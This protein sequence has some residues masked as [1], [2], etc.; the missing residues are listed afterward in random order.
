MDLRI[1]LQP[2]SSK[3]KPH[4]DATEITYPMPTDELELE[5]L[6]GYLKDDISAALEDYL[7]S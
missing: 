4:G 1:T 7:P 6:A 2:V 5:D 3:G